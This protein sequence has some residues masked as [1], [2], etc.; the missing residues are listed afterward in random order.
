LS[1]N[2]EGI[3]LKKD[4]INTLNKYGKLTLENIDY[5]RYK[6]NNNGDSKHKKTIQE[7]L[8]VLQKD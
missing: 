6:S 8:Y 5:L 7:Q 4:I 2:S 3:M 1:Y